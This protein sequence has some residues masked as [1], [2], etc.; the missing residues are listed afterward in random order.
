MYSNFN[1]R[2]PSMTNPTVNAFSSPSPAPSTSKTSSL[3][4]KN[5]YGMP[6]SQ[7]APTPPSN[8]L[9]SDFQSKWYA[10]ANK[11]PGQEAQAQY[12]QAM[13]QSNADISGGLSALGFRGNQN[14]G[15]MERLAG[16][17]MQ[18]R[19]GIG[20]NATQSKY[21]KL[22]ELYGQGLQQIDL[23]TMQGKDMAAGLK[24]AERQG[25]F[26]GNIF[27]NLGF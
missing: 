14:A 17:G 25:D 19:G 5:P 1:P 13:G 11:L 6:Q 23:P 22:A 8:A 10:L 24:N 7:G 9:P 21:N 3:V 4:A 27:N 18:A 20:T 26:L 12:G 2:I 15:S 16:A